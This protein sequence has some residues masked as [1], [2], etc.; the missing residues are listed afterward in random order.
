MVLTHSCPTG[1]DY[2]AGSVAP[3]ARGVRGADGTL[4]PGSTGASA[5]YSTLNTGKTKVRPTIH[6]AFCPNS[7]LAAR[8]TF[9]VSTI[10]TSRTPAPTA[11]RIP[12]WICGS[13]TTPCSMDVG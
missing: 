2:Y 5:K 11:A 4:Q 12:G 8:S 13:R 3:V 10:Q 9:T 6:P 1:A 7:R